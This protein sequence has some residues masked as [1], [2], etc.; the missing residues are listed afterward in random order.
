MPDQLHWLSATLW[1][2]FPLHRTTMSSF[3]IHLTSIN[4]VQ[5]NTF[6]YVYL[7]TATSWSNVVEPEDLLKARSL[8][9]HIRSNQHLAKLVCWLSYL[10]RQCTVLLH[11]PPPVCVD[12]YFGLSVCLS[13]CLSKWD[14]S[15]H[16]RQCDINLT[17]L[18]LYTA[19]A[20]QDGWSHLLVSAP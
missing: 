3:N 20:R 13:V 19:H 17:I 11:A 5:R 1:Q 10:L 4:P 18:L 9:T 14:T 12:A 6:F 7:I 2:H 8:C 15:N 16:T